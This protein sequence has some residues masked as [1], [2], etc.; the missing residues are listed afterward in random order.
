MVP[1]FIVTLFVHATWGCG[2]VI[3]FLLVDKNHYAQIIETFLC[4][5]LDLMRQHKGRNGN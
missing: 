1:R 2:I 4:N 5:M 3:S